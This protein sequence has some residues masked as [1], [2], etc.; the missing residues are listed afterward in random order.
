MAPNIGLVVGSRG[1]VF[2]TPGSDLAQWWDDVRGPDGQFRNV[3]WV[4]RGEGSTGSKYNASPC[5]GCRGPNS[6]RLHHADPGPRPGLLLQRP[7]DHLSKA[8]HAGL[9]PSLPPQRSRSRGCHRRVRKRAEDV[10]PRRRDFLDHAS[11]VSDPSPV[12][13]DGKSPP[14]PGP[15]CNSHFDIARENCCCSPHWPLDR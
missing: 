12:C 1:P 8:E 9:G 5:C 14:K 11:S 6:R 15:I 3:M 4:A 7:P 10:E 2:E 13:R